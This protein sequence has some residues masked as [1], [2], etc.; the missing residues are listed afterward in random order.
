M[1]I[2]LLLLMIYNN[3]YVEKTGIGTLNQWLSDSKIFS[4]IFISLCFLFVINGANLI[5][6]Y[7]GLLGLHT[8]IILLNLFFINYLN[9][10]FFIEL[11]EMQNIDNKFFIKFILLKF[12]FIYHIQ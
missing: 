9:P 5:D 8:L 11:I 1:V 7:N 2:F 6:G 3:F 10:Y 12:L 4:L